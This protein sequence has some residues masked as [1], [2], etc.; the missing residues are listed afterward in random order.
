MGFTGYYHWFILKFI[1]IAGPLHEL[2]SGDTGDNAGRKKATITCDNRCQWSF[3]GLKHLCTIVPVLAHKYLYGS[4]FDIYTD[5]NPL[6][7]ILMMEKLDEVSLAM[8]NFQLHYRVGKANMAMDALSRVSWPKCMTNTMG[9]YHQ[10][11]HSSPGSA[12]LH[13]LGPVCV[14]L[15]HTAV[16]YTFWT[17]LKT[18]NR[19]HVW[20]Q[21][22][23]NRPSWLT[24]FWVKWLWGCR[25][26]LWGNIRSSQPTQGGLRTSYMNT[27]ILSWGR[28]FSIKKVLQRESQ[29]ALFQL[30]LPP[31]HRETALRGCH[32]D[33]GHL[34]LKGIVDLMCDHFFWPQMAVH[35]KKHIRI[36]HQDITC[37]ARQ[38]R[39]PGK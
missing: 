24:P 34:G 18:A 26:G 25:M 4:T 10:I 33:I 30:V 16:T 17:L 27:I 39:A 3:D 20:P 14:S 7:Y 38:Q 12:G 35:V 29:E 2:T 23:G 22:T 9:S 15:K 31:A 13:P 21:R 32:D 1:Q 37:K 19:L 6:T 5:N 8:Y 36:C 11:S 28:A